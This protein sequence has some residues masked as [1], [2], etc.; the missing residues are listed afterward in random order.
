MSL[1][2]EKRQK[3]KKLIELAFDNPD[4]EEG[5][6]A[7]WRALRVIR[8]YNLLDATPLDG[9]LENETVRAVKDV[10][11]VVTNPEFVGNLKSLGRTLG[12]LAAAA[13]ARRRR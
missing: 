13:K 10:A 3:A 9:V 11:D 8:K 7:A 2:E 12:G 4:S 5:D 6:A 1:K